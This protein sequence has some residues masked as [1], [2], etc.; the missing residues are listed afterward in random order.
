MKVGKADPIIFEELK[1][2][3]RPILMTIFLLT[4]FNLA[5]LV[6]NMSVQSRADVAGMD[7]RELKR[8]R[9]FKRAVE[10]IVESILDDKIK[11]IVE[12]CRVYNGSISC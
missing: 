12:D 3:N 7:Y 1:M 10:G 9:D 6:I 2:Q 5:I 11:K 4:L 8:D